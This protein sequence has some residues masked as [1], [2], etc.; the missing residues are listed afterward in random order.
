MCQGDESGGNEAEPRRASE[1]AWVGGVAR[2]GSTSKGSARGSGGLCVTRGGGV[3]CSE[4]AWR[5]W[6]E[7]SGGELAGVEDLGR[8]ASSGAW[9]R[10]GV[11]ARV[12]WAQGSSGMDGWRSRGGGAK[13]RWGETTAAAGNRV[14]TKM[15]EEDDWMD[16]FVKRKKYRGLSVN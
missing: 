8:Q 5:F 16:L 12:N 9:G 4:A 1:V 3:H 15:E 14:P 2:A 13:L 10:G 11:P 7:N 6:G